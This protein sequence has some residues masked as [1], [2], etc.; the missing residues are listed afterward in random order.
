MSQKEKFTIQ[1]HDAL[2]LCEQYG[3]PLYVYNTAK[4]EEQY[5]RLQ[6]AFKGSKLKIN[7]A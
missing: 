2:A 1:G 3:A 6:K 5:K 7:Y 4:M